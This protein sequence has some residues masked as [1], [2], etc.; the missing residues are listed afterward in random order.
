M[1]G[2]AAVTKT[3]PSLTHPHSQKIIANLILKYN[4]KF[5]KTDKSLI[6]EAF[7]S[8]ATVFTQHV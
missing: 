1:Y 6:S 4:G 2:Q 8:G 5:W 7:I 3:F